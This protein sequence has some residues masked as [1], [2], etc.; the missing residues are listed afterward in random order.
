MRGLPSWIWIPMPSKTLAVQS[1][2]ML[3]NVNGIQTRAKQMKAKL[4]DI[5][6]LRPNKSYKY[7][8]TMHT[9]V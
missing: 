6:V 8:A 9:Q 3:G 2:G 4:I 1:K 7:P 5:I